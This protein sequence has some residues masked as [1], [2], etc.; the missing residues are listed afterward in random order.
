M[1][2]YLTR[3][4][5]TMTALTITLLLGTAALLGFMLVR[6]GYFDR[7]LTGQLRLR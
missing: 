2:R 6:Q 7:W 4:R 1:R 3:R 5:L